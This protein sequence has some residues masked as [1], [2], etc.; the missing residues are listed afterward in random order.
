MPGSSQAPT[1]A[2]ATGGALDA[3]TAAKLQQIIDHAAAAH[4]V[5]GISAAVLLSDGRS[6]TG[7]SG[8][9]QLSPARPVD[10]G[11]DFAIAS[12]TKTFVTAAIMQLVGDGQLSLDEPLSRWLPSFPD[13]RHITVRELLS[14]TSGIYN[15]FENPLY[16][17]LVFSNPNRRWTFA[18]IMALVKTPYCAPGACYHYSN[19]NFVILGRIVEVITGKPI[20]SVI[21]GRLL[22]P[23]A[24]DHTFFQPYDRTPADAAHGFVYAGGPQVDVTGNSSVIPTMSS[25]TVAWAAGAMVSSATDLAHWATALYGGDVVQASLL[26]QMET[27]KACHDYY[28]LGTRV[29]FFSGRRAVGHL[30]S[31]R[32]YIDE[33]WYFPHEGA[34]IVLLSNQGS[35]DADATVGRLSRALFAAIGAPAPQYPTTLTTHAHDSVTLYCH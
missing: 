9:R 30:G 11:T 16:N 4:H 35:W 8:D 18:Q 28:G 23:D 24:L 34:A 13:A 22:A 12:I 3:A 26:A 10:T 20:S 33:M 29:Y 7:L 31:L 14:H 6:W 17:G 25:A 2:P 1:P 15:Y 32:G 21:Y 5:P 19:T 27:A